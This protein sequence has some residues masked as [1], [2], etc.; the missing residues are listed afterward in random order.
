MR[1]RGGTHPAGSF[2]RVVVV[3]LAVVTSAEVADPSTA[4][5]PSTA[6]APL[7]SPAELAARPLLVVLFERLGGGV[8]VVAAMGRQVAGCDGAPEGWV[9]EWRLAGWPARPLVGVAR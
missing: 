4:R 2:P 8:A 7:V 1:D 5:I 3:V 9:G 6:E